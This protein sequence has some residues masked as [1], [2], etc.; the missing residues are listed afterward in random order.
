MSAKPRGARRGARR[1][2]T[3][4]LVAML[5]SVL[6]GMTA[7]AVDLSRLYV[8][9]GQLR[10]AADAGALAGAV[11]LSHQRLDSLRGAAAGY[12]LSNRVGGA[13]PAV[14]EGDV[15]VGIWD[16]DARSFTPVAPP[17]WPSQ[18][19]NAVR[20]V[21]RHSAS[22]TFGRIFDLDDRELGASAT[23]AVGYVAD[24]SCVKPWALDYGD[25]V[26]AL[27]GGRGAATG[28]LDPAD[29]NAIALADAGARRSSRFAIDATVQ[30]L[31]LDGGY[32]GY[33]G[34]G[35]R[36][37]Q[38]ITGCSAR[39]IEPGDLVAGETDAAAAGELATRTA[40][41]RFCDA[42]GG[43]SGYEGSASFSCRG[44]PKVKVV[45]WNW[46]QVT[47]RR[48]TI[49]SIT[50]RVKYVGVVRIAGYGGAPA[51][52]R[53][54]FSTMAARGAFTTDATPLTRV[55]LVR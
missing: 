33:G 27:T 32:G 45:L 28:A 34:Y 16:F 52:L 41:W 35:S 36:Y 13:E 43:A 40:L 1:G 23:A 9:R 42:N 11:E 2:A 12:A 48:G 24:A 29:I 44:E 47:R 55:V 6:I 21:T 3:L 31:R 22:L 50:Y 25:L 26:D 7:L 14:A 4:V 38:N 20:V 17:D 46:R 15:Q 19:V 30:P 37:A 49:T 10:A 54:Y 5:M 53:G 51:R 8:M 18:P 39:D